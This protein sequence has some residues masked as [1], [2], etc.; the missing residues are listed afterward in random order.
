MKRR[1]KRAA[2]NER[3]QRVQVSFARCVVI[4]YQVFEFATRHIVQRQAGRLSY[5]FG[6]N[7]LRRFTEIN[8]WT[9]EPRDELV[10][11]FVRQ[12]EFRRPWRVMVAQ[13]IQASFEPVHPFRITN[14]IL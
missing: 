5:S 4:E 11:G 9:F 14:R 1:F 12:I 13:S 2:A 8:V 6:Q 10:I 7:P 3:P